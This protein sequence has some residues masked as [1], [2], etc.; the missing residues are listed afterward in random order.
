MNRS[1]HQTKRNRSFRLIFC[2]NRR[3]LT[4]VSKIASNRNQIAYLGSSLRQCYVYVDVWQK[5]LSR[6]VSGAV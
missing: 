2:S 4:T 5:P 1:F 6:K 3:F